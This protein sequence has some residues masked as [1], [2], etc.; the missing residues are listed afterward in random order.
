MTKPLRVVAG[1]A[2]L[3]FMAVGS[4]GGPLLVPTETASVISEADQAVC[5]QGAQPAFGSL[6]DCDRLHGTSCSPPGSTTLC[7]W[8]PTE[9][10]ICICQGSN[11]DCYSW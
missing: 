9:P 4:V 10:D 5:I 7:L 2:I 11:W 6:P 3:T 8:T 1:L